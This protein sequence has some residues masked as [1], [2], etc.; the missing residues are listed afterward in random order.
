MLAPELK[1]LLK[2]MQTIDKEA[3]SVEKSVRHWVSPIDRTVAGLGR[4]AREMASVRREAHSV[5]REIAKTG[6]AMSSLKAAGGMDKQM[7]AWASAMARPLAEM[8]TMRSTTQGVATA[9]RGVSRSIDSWAGRINSAAA[10]MRRMNSA[11]SGMRLPN[12]SHGSGGGGGAGTQRVRGLQSARRTHGGHGRHGYVQHEG[13][14]LAGALGV[15]GG[16]HF[17]EEVIKTGVEMRHIELGMRQTGATPEQ[18]EH[19]KQ[20]SYEGSQKF[21]NLSPIEIFEHIN[22]LRGILGTIDQAIHE[23]P[24]LLPEFSAMK[25]KTGNKG[26]KGAVNQIYTAVKSA[27]TANEITPE[28]VKKHTN[29]LLRLSYWYGDKLNPT[30]YFTAQKNAGQML[31]VTSD[32]FRFGPFAALTQ[33]IGQKA[34]T[35][36]GTFAAKGI[37]GLRMMVSGLTDA[38]HYDLL[39]K[40]TVSW[41][42][43]K[44]KV[45]PG[46]QFSDVAPDGQKYDRAKDPDLWL[47]HVVI[48]K[49]KAGGV[50]TDDK[51]ELLR[52]LGKIFSDKNAYGLLFTL[53]QQRS[54]LEKD[55]KGYNATSGDSAAYV[56]DNPY[57]SG[58]GTVAQT[59]AI[60]A[61]V[62]GPAIPGMVEHLNRINAALGGI[63]NTLEK[64][65]VAAHTVFGTGAG[66]VG[67]A[68][69]AGITALTI[70]AV[71]TVGLPSLVVGS[72]AALTISA[73][74]LPWGAFGDALG[75]K[76]AWNN[77]GRVG[78]SGRPEDVGKGGASPF[79]KPNMGAYGFTRGLPG[80]VPPGAKVMP[81]I[82]EQAWG[83]W[84]KE[85]LSSGGDFRRGGSRRSPFGADPILPGLVVPPSM[86][87][88]GAPPAVGAR[89][90][91][92]PL[93]PPPMTPGGGAPGMPEFVRSAGA[94]APGLTATAA[95][96]NAVQT[97]A[98]A[99]A[100]G[101][102]GARGGINAV[103]AAADG[104]GG[105]LATLAARISGLSSMGL[106]GSAAG[107]GA[108]AGPAGASGPAPA[109]GGAGA[110][111]AGPA[112]PGKQ[113]GVVYRSNSG[114]PVQM[115]ANLNVDGRRMARVVSDQFV[116]QHDTRN[117]A[118]GHDSNALQTP[119]GMR[120]PV[121]A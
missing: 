24:D 56:R 93:M 116:A 14:H 45:Q 106:P 46:A 31:N 62:S 81:T 19:A 72:V 101:L 68:A 90:M 88:R 110:A 91:T 17:G 61:A 82:P 120:Y 70:A 59:T 79:F 5:E 23:A 95:G 108:K 48:P 105:S 58:Q 36:F 103:K 94:A 73:L 119:V 60:G 38:Y 74:T 66:L 8:R 77:Y 32:R 80:M 96:L 9:A 20:V 89:T 102:D 33:E 113:S 85:K 41:N 64:H 39:Q 28:G 3:K 98:G 65:P 69:A 114:P 112:A 13:S 37:A 35:Q 78:R 86:G 115:V 111:P 100:G 121:V 87:T 16:V 97:A 40:N 6:R 29:S 75:I 47:Y 99:V 107:G 49:L 27:E 117:R 104:A 21:P 50:N 7:A 83:D 118:S 15:T 71:G 53:A 52:V 44:T 57:A 10:A 67:G 63:A 1:S 11:A 55:T 109:G 42:K 51:T 2:N 25:A 84:L 4:V 30:D 92:M 22:D 34:G 43:K 18:I 76:D 54:K 26:S 12:P